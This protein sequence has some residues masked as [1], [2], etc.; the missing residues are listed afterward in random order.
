MKHLKPIFKNKEVNYFLKNKIKVT[1]VS[2]CIAFMTLTSCGANDDDSIACGNGTWVQSVQTEL[3][4]WLTATQAYGSD[5]TS[6]NCQNYK[7]TGQA[8]LNALDKIKTCVPVVN[9]AEF[10]KALLEAK[11]ALEKTSC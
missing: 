6:A 4:T 5:P 10:E 2:C 9:L 8:Y 7:S 11:E 3:N 1:L